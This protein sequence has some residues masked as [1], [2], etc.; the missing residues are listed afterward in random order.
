MT[1]ILEALKYGFLQKALISG[2]FISILCAVL[3]VF[4]VLKRL[5]L[6]GDGLS[7]VTFFSVALGFLLHASPLFVSIPVVVLSSLGI[8]KLTEKGRVFGDTAIGIISSVGIAGGILLASAAG[9]FNVDLFS[10]LFG[11]ILTISTAEVWSSIILSIIVIALIIIFYRD[12]VAVTFDEESSKVLGIKASNINRILV[13]LTSLTVVLA[14]KI[15]GIM[16]ISSFLILPAAAALQLAVSFGSTIMFAS[17]F[18]LVSVI[19]GVILSFVFNLPTGAVIVMI[20]FVVFLL[21][22][23]VRKI[24][25]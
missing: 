13:V 23:F 4:L 24:R 1:D 7:H 15:I 12:L 21:A 8:L 10:Y 17:M 2:M 3:G 5:S 20:N 19:L 16:L 18:A 25:S 11:N 6:I 9:G 22:M 14:M